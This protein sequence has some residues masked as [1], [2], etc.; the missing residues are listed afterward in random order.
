[1]T[2][3]QPPPGKNPFSFKTF[4]SRK[5]Q[6]DDG[7]VTKVKKGPKKAKEKSHGDTLLPFPEVGGPKNGSFLPIF[8]S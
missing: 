3:E 1:M 5:A 7:D 8:I 6:G 2:A 4:V